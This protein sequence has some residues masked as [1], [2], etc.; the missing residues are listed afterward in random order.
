MAIDLKNIDKNND[1]IINSSELISAFLEFGLT[2]NEKNILLTDTEK[3]E[4]KAKDV[5]A[6][7]GLTLEQGAIDSALVL[8]EYGLIPSPSPDNCEK[9]RQR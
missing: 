6:K 1:K 8:A 5:F 9:V 3:F 2:K 4:A 7:A